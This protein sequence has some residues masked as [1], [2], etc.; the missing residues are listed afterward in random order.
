MWEMT[1]YKRHDLVWLSD[2]GLDCAA[3]NIQNC[4][5][6]ETDKELRALLFSSPPVPA[7]VRR[8]ESTE[9]D[10][11][12]V[13]F[14]FP[15]IIDGTRLR[16]STKVPLD[17]V[18]R[19][20]TPFEILKYETDNLPG[21]EAVRALMDA[22]NMYHTKVGLFGSAALQ[23]ATGLPYWQTNSDLDIYLRHFGSGQEL[24]LFYKQL[25]FI[26]GQFDV[27]ID[28]EIEYQE[29]YG[30]KLKELFGLGKT[31]LGKGLYDVT[32]L[33]KPCLESLL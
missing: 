22:G 6:H 11:L 5:P 29:Q 32:L 33:E 12:C 19:H 21:K 27:T 23:L 2:A 15:R 28:A 4:I 10:L 13:G 24:T 8:Q 17:S 30:V 31:V 3:H 7:I 26:E 20:K 14:S 1:A 18:V 9:D 16:L 25:A